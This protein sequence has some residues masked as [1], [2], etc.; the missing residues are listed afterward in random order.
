LTQR[1]RVT[2]GQTNRRTDEQIDGSTVLASLALCI[3][4]YADA[5]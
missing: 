2:D 1:Q 3:A 5:L 4:R